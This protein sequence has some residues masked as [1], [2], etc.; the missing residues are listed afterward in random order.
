MNQDD[1]N[2]IAKVFSDDYYVIVTDNI[3]RVNRKYSKDNI[4]FNLAKKIYL[5]N[6]TRTDS[7]VKKI[8]ETLKIL[9]WRQ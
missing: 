5:V 8:N 7:L 3:L 2:K 4:V 1:L 6:L 9:G